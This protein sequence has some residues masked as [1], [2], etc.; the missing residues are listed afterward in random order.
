MDRTSA[1]QTLNE[2]LESGRETRSSIARKLSIHP[3][4]VSRIAS[5]NFIRLDGH[6][7]KVCKFA[8]SATGA[9]R[10]R[11]QELPDQ[12]CRLQSL[13]IELLEQHPE[14]ADG[15][16]MLMESLITPQQGFARA[17]RQPMAGGCHVAD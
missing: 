9:E 10:L 13:L 16:E 12:Y 6:A 2:L 11:K 1:I 3:S 15:L 14:V 4:Q 17:V 8:Q 7:L 5:G